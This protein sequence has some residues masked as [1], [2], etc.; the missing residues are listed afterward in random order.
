MRKI[1]MI[2]VSIAGM[3]LNSVCF[4]ADSTVSNN[5]TEIIVTA[6]REKQEASKAPANVTVIDSSE[7]EGNGNVSLLDALKKAEGIFVRSTTDNPATAEVSM[8]GFGENAHGRVLVLVDGHRINRPDM[9]RVNW[10]QIPL[11]D[12]DR[13]EIVRGNGSALYGNNAL[14]GVINV[15]TKKGKDASSWLSFNTGSFDTFDES[16]GFAGNNNELSWLISGGRFESD[17]YRDRSYFLSEQANC[18]LGYTVSKSTEILIS[19]LTQSD[20]YHLPGW[21]TKEQL[22]QDRRQSTTPDDDAENDY[23]DISSSFSSELA[24]DNVFDVGVSFRRRDSKSNMASWFSYSDAI[25]DTIA[26]TPKYSVNGNIAGN[27]NTL[28]SG[29]DIYFDSL[30][31]DRYGERERTA[32]AVDAAVDRQTLGAYLRDEY[33]I[34]PSSV[35]GLGA[36][37]E[38]AD[39]KADVMTAGIKSV[40]QS[41]TLDKA[42]YDLSLIKTYENRSKIYAKGGTVYRYPFVD[43]QVSYY[44]FGSDQFFADLKAEEGWNI[45]SG[46]ELR[47]GDSLMIGM[48]AF[49]MDMKNEIV[50]DYISQKN[51][52]MD[53][54]RREGIEADAAFELNKVV[55]IRGNYSFTDAIFTSGENEDKKIPL[56]PV[57]KAGIGADLD[58]PADTM[59]SADIVYTG[60]SF[61]GNDNANTDEKI[62][63]YLITNIRLGFQPSAVKG[64]NLYVGADNI[65]DTQYVSLAYKGYPENG[66]YSMP[67][68]T[69]KGGIRYQF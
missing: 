47:I 51:K 2:A 49:V 23:F 19:L 33:D 44:G 18:K 40:D 52:N 56:V 34:D 31:I 36:R 26:V 39:T 58:L 30:E 28:I 15:I 25:I 12:V 32:K 62:D 13:V 3:I 37:Y 14:S 45:E 60:S 8:R 63:S 65:F 16:F 17:G 48:T 59:L 27:K 1:N 66:Y 6:N 46:G 61:I 50:W 10:L 21:L 55:T 5:T 68:R 35:F 38:S 64:L 22:E 4:G 41:K 69:F 20:E 7:I 53:K 42:S 57:H 24:Q 29:V 43:E 11:S 9:S 67:G 54:T